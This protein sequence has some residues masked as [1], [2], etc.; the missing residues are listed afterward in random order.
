M[1]QKSY[2]TTA[3]W[4]LVRTDGARARL[5]PEPDNFYLMPPS[6]PILTEWESAYSAAFG[7]SNS[8]ALP[9]PA[10]SFR[11]RRRLVE[12]PLACGEALFRF[13]YRWKGAGEFAG[14]VT[15]PG[16]VASNSLENAR[17]SRNRDGPHLFTDVELA[18]V[19]TFGAPVPDVGGPPLRPS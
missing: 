5:G 1:P 9:A 4:G 6:H 7:T 14:S 15:D 10:D 19:T 13:P 2:I 8:S 17:M 18:P 16:R 12:R 3:Y 11:L